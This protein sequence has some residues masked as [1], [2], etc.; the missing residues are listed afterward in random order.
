[1][2]GDVSRGTT[3]LEFRSCYH[4]KRRLKDCSDVY[5]ETFEYGLRK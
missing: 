1:M 5:S 2:R 3:V 4:R